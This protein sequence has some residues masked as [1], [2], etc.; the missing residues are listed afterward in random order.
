MTTAL[1]PHFAIV[2]SGPS[3]CYLAQSLLRGF[4]HSAITVFDRLVSPFGLIRYG[5]AA[6]HQHTK[7]ITR[8]F[9]RLFQ[10]PAVRFAGNVEVGRD[11]SLDELRESYD[12][13]ILATGLSADRG[14]DLPGSTLPGVIG[15]GAITRALNA[16]PDE[17]AALPPLGSDVVL[18]GAGNVALDILRFL[19]KGRDGYIES[20][21]ADPTLNSYLSDPALRITMVSRSTAPFT[22][23]DPLMIRELAEL[24][25]ASYV[26]DSLLTRTPQAAAP[27]R[28]LDRVEAARIAAWEALLSPDRGEHP[29][30]QVSLTFG[31]IP[32]RILGDAHVEGVEVLV[33]EKRVTIPAS[34]VITAVG[35]AASGHLAHLLSAS[36]EIGLIDTGLYR[37]GWAKRGPRGAIPENR[38]CAKAVAA[39]I[40]ADIA[41][42]KLPVLAS[43]LGFS[44]LPARVSTVAIN[45]EQWLTLEAH[46]REHAPSDRIRQKI[47]EHDRMVAIARGEASD[48]A[49]TA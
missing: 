1:R 49:S 31:A 4:P 34:S 47:S 11:V 33:D 18:L 12:A 13:V 43:R 20:D 42:G 39:E 3:G 8:Q 14:L 44:G 28:E 37:T 29:G 19:V 26:A 45:Y 32:C 30:P 10:N 16:H 7:A 36:S 24:P 6:D 41:S 17:P 15:A 25:R 21:I 27:E 9:E 46:E 40:T 22:K 35:F 23:G 5:V 48:P 38:A 2:G